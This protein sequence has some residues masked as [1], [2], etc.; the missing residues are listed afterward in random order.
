MGRKQKGEDQAERRTVFR[1]TAL[2]GRDFAGIQQWIDRH[3]ELPHEALA[4]AICRRFGWRQANGLWAV[5]ACR[6]FLRRVASR[7]W[8]CLP[9][10][11]RSG[12]FVQSRQRPGPPPVV[13]GGFAVRQVEGAVVVRPITAAERPQ[14]QQHMGSHHYLGACALIGESLCYVATVGGQWVA[15]LGWAAA[16]L[17]NT[18]R[19]QYLGWDRATKARRLSLVVNNVR[20]LVLPWIRQPHLASR[21]LAANLRRLSADWRR[22]LARNSRFTEIVGSGP[23]MEDVFLA[24]SENDP[25]ELTNVAG[26]PKNAAI[27]ASLSA[28]LERHVSTGLECPEA[29]VV[30]KAPDKRPN[31]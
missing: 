8:L 22:D 6:L 14:W 4:G 23:E 15:L 28:D 13:S 26:D 31:P 30:R 25:D 10:P 5:S 21:I 19:D 3:R 20:F 12:N 9:P 29:N 1:G 7:G 17:R 27:L 18:P 16:A 2:S 24:N 11:R